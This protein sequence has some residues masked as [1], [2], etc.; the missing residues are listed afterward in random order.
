MIFTNKKSSLRQSFLFIKKNAKNT[1]KYLSIFSK[2]GYTNT[3]L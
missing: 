3:E 2:L 1:N